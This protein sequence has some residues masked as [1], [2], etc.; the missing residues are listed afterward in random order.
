M[1]IAIP[2][3]L[4]YYYY[5]PL[6]DTFFK[7]LGFEVV[8]TGPTTK[9]ILDK[10][11]KAAVADICAPIKIFTGHVIEGLNVADYVFVPR[12]ARIKKPEYFCPKFMGLPDIIEGT[13]EESKGRVI[14]PIINEK[15][16]ENISSPKIYEMLTEMFGFS[17]REIRLAMRKAEEVFKRFKNL[18]NKGLSCDKALDSYRRGI[19]EE[20][21]KKVK[22]DGDITIA[23][24]GYVYDVYD[25]FISMDVIKKT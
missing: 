15:N 19:W 4:L 6:W 25:S 17:H 14:S 11:S 20:N 21:L 23:V 16:N 22:K 10:G 7:E 13:V 24:L 12:F 18:M 8:D 9:G 1:K 2:H 3:S 5:F